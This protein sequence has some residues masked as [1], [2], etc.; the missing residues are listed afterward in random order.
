M[1]MHVICNADIYEILLFTY[2]IADNNVKTKKWCVELK[3]RQTQAF[4]FN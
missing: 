3:K 4:S 2:V 1:P